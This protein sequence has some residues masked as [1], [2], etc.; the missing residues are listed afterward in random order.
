MPMPTLHVLQQ[1]C[2]IAKPFVTKIATVR[3]FR[4]MDKFMA[5]QFAGTDAFF[6]AFWTFKAFVSVDSHLVVDHGIGVRK[7]HQADSAFA[8]L[9]AMTLYVL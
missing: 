4:R 1:T 6:V 9:L 8:W 7:F 3:L 2:T 5:S